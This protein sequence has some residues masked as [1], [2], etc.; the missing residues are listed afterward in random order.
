MAKVSANQIQPVYSH[1]EGLTD[2]QFMLSMTDFEEYC[3]NS[4]IY[5]KNGHPVT[6]ELNEAQKLTAD[7]ILK[8]IEPILTKK[9]TPSIRVCIHK[10]RQMGITTLCLKL[11]QYIM[12]KVTHFNTIHIMPT[13]PEADELRDR[14]LMPMLQATHPDLMPVMI[15]SGNH[16]DFKE[17]EGNLLDN[18][19]TYGSAGAKGGYHGRMSPVDT[20]IITPDGWKKMGELKVGDRVFGRDG[21]PTN[22][23]GVYPQGEKQNYIVRMKNGSQLEAGLEHRWLIKGGNVITTE[24]MLWCLDQHE[25]VQIPTAKT[26]VLDSGEEVFS[27][28][29]LPEYQQVESITPSREVE[30]VCIAVDNEDHTY[31]SG[32]DFVVSHNTIHCLVEDEHCFGAGVEVMTDRGLVP[33]EDI[34]KDHKVAQWSQAGGGRV[35]FVNPTYLH[36]YDNPKN[37][38]SLKV[39]N[40]REVIVT[41]Q[42]EFVLRGRRTGGYTKKKLEDISFNSHWHIPMSGEG[43]NNIPLTDFD[44][45]V[46]AA[47]ADGHISRVNS[48]RKSNMRVKFTLKLKRKI[49]RLNR[50]I[51]SV[52]LKSSR[53]KARGFTQI[54]VDFPAY[55]NVKELSPYLTFDANRGRALEILEEMVF[56]DGHREKN[57]RLYYS[58]TNKTNVELFAYIGFQAGYNSWIGYQDPVWRCRLKKGES[59]SIQNFKRKKI[60]YDKP[61]YCLTV[62]SG[63]IVV[64]LGTGLFVTGNS[65]YI[66]P[67]TLEAGLLPA[68]SGNTIRIVLFTAKGMNH[69]YD[70][71]KT[72]QDPESDW[73]YLFLPWYLLSEYEMTPV[74]K[75]ESLRGLSD[76]DIFLFEEF[77]RAGVPKNKWQAKA[78]WYNYTFINEAKRDTKYMYENYPTIAEESFKASGSPIFD[79]NKIREWE[80]QPHKKLDVFYREGKTV[81]EYTDDGVIREK[82]PPRRGQ[83]Y[84][85]GADPADG[86]VAGDDSALVVFKLTDDKI[87]AVC[88]Y[89]G[90]ISQNDFA[91]L[92]YDV[93]MRYNEALIVPERNTG[94]LMIKWLTEIKGYFNIWTDVSKVSNYNNLGVYTTVATKNEAI[95]R[96]K[97]LINNG[98]Y[99]DFDPRFCEQAKYFTYE[100]TPS[101]QLRAAAAGGHHDDT[102]MCRVIAMMALDMERFGNYNEMAIKDGRKY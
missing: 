33:I 61:V 70:L 46:I 58:S 77:K 57:G 49:D 25:L 41:G 66:D 3:R 87:S 100:R 38:Y 83:T 4:I 95:G 9:P 79:A 37:V 94:Q 73:V 89:N 56:W 32:L 24:E 85:I 99:E 63:N 90:S 67:F 30:S 88:S 92:L 20:P 40:D 91:E 34:T 74:G 43:S 78:M 97:F 21:S 62:P 8:A 1:W 52:G 75:Y 19:L 16:I 6:F 50:L 96:I 23:I 82:E 68:M 31:I 102:V 10:S 55:I 45:L 5:D 7:T 14:K 35:E 84:I 98:H 76:Y 93:A 44:R 72:A 80:K 101:G 11:E 13:E 27:N 12:S 65:K 47:Q 39:H 22:V 60:E 2:E 59:R 69:S 51:D 64:K 17:F 26:V 36:K 28:R 81:F 48:T 71:S 54:D 86:E 53:C 15:S 18:R 29:G 42:H